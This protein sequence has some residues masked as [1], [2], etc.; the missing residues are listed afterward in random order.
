[1]ALPSPVYAQ[2]CDLFP[3]EGAAEAGI[4]LGLSYKGPS[5]P[6]AL[7]H[8]EVR[9]KVMPD[10]L[11]ALWRDALSYVHAFEIAPPR[12]LEE[13]L[14]WIAFLGMCWAVAK[15]VWRRLIALIAA[16][17]GTPVIRGSALFVKIVRARLEIFAKV[18]HMDSRTASLAVSNDVIFSTALIP[19][20]LGLAFLVSSA[21]PS[22]QFLVGLA[23][24]GFGFLWFLAVFSNFTTIAFLRGAPSKWDKDLQKARAVRDAALAN[25]EGLTPKERVEAQQLDADL[26]WLD[27]WLS[28]Y[29]RTGRVPIDPPKHNT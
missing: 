21:S 28:T 22:A 7:G 17:P 26:S 10:W 11:Y 24:T 29:R 2:G 6:F 23:L 20:A 13:L 4:H 15:A 1:M 14:A 27:T 9:E 19:I 18:G 12:K 16:A 3:R 5:G 8:C 25:P